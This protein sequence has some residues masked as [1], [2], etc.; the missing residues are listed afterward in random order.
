MSWATALASTLPNPEADTGDDRC[1]REHSANKVEAY[2]MTFAHKAIYINM[3]S[4]KKKL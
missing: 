3:I 4:L 1:G 2:S